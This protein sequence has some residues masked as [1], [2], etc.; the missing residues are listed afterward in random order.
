MKIFK[1]QN[2]MVLHKKLIGTLLVILLSGW[3]IPT[4]AQENTKH[5]K[6]QITF[7]YPLGTNGA[8][9]ANYTNNVSFNLLMGVNGGVNGFEFGGL[10]NYNKGNVRGFQFSELVNGRQQTNLVLQN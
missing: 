7:I 6:S 8:N 4:N 1:T 9:S 10:V 2:E 3:S 5:K